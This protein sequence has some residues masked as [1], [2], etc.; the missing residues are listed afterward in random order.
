MKLLNMHVDNFGGLHNYDFVFEDGLNVVLHENG[1]GKTTMAAFLKAML[2]GFDSKRSKSITENER[3]RYLPWQGGV[4]GGYLEFEAEG[5]PYRIYRTFGETPR[6]DKTKIINLNTNKAANINTENIGETLFGLDANAFQRSAFINQNGL[7][8]EGAAS[9]I[10]T[11]LNALVSQAND[12]SAYDDAIA[13][14]TSQMKVYEK[15]GGRG[16][17]GE[18]TRKISELEN[19]RSNLDATISKQDEARE[20]ISQLNVL[21]SALD[22]DLKKKKAEFDKI[23]GKAKKAEAS[24]ELLNQISAQISQLQEQISA[25]KSD[26]GNKLPTKAEI[27]QLKQKKQTL[28]ILSSQKAQQEK[29]I[30]SLTQGYEA[31]LEKYN[32]VLPTTAQL[33]E[34]QSIYAERQ[35]ILSTSDTDSIAT[36]EAPD[37]YYILQKATANNPEYLSKLQEAINLQASLQQLLTQLEHQNRDISQESSNWKEKKKR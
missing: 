19:Q 3:K 12:V 17:I 27:D 16:R 18:I 15:T 6:F 8:V 23:S 24:K 35:G 11:R 37:G 25:L 10:H 21:I 13:N 31:L 34:I 7:S 29:D 26:L 14:L 33:D 2:Y 32:N 9:S 36:E 20:R 30:I 1:W 28:D 4:Y 22:E 5:I